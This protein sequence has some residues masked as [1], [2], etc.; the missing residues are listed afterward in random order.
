MPSLVIGVMLAQLMFGQPPAAP[1]PDPCREVRSLDEAVA[2][3]AAE[4]VLRDRWGLAD[5][6][7]AMEQSRQSREARGCYGPLP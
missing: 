6:L 5:Y 3:L 4:D 7:E 1:P 2:V